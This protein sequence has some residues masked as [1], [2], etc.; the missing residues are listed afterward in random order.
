MYSTGT[1]LQIG[2]LNTAEFFYLTDPFWQERLPEQPPLKQIPKAVADLYD[3]WF[4]FGIDQDLT[5]LP[6]AYKR[7]PWGNSH[8]FEAKVSDLDDVLLFFDISEL[9]MLAIDIEGDELAV[10]EEYSWNV[11]PAFITVEV[12]RQ[13]QS[14]EEACV[15]IIN[16]VEPHGYNVYNCQ[17]S[18]YNRTY[19]LQFLRDDLPMDAYQLKSD[20]RWVTE[21]PPITEL[22][23][24]INNPNP[25]VAVYFVIFGQDMETYTEEAIYAYRQLIRH[26][27]IAEVGKIHFFIEGTPQAHFVEGRLTALGLNDAISFITMGDYKLA[28]YIPLMQHRELRDAKYICFMDTDMWLLSDGHPRLDWRGITAKWDEYLPQSVFG[29]VITIDP[30]HFFKQ[31]Y[32]TPYL[33]TLISPTLPEALSLSG[34]FIALRQEKAHLIVSEFY[35]VPPDSMDEVFW[36]AFFYNNPHWQPVKTLAENIPFACIDNYKEFEATFFINV[37]APDFLKNEAELKNLEKLL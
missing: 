36:K 37:G 21:L 8:F 18:N 3:R 33:E 11:K 9:G 34:Y 27:N 17:Q 26:T 15:A 7:N 1:C 2:L 24:V 29:D 22:L 30:Q 4:Y 20:G 28:R 5:P 25:L 13:D 14:L 19:E 35:Q 6:E 16:L 12:H 31:A 32:I 10:F 23:P